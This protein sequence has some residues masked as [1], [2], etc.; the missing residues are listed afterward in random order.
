MK[1]VFSLKMGA[2]LH[3]QDRADEEA[4][5]KKDVEAILQAQ[6]EIL[7]EQRKHLIHAKK[8]VAMLPVRPE[9]L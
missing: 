9:D 2:I 5:R 6:D 1:N 7:D 3:A 8:A 4:Q